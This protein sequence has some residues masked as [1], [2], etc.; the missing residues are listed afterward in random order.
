MCS[1]LPLRSGN[2]Q[3]S[4]GGKWQGEVRVQ[5]VRAV[6]EGKKGSQKAVRTKNVQ[7]GDATR[8]QKQRRGHRATLTGV[9]KSSAYLGAR[10]G[11]RP[12]MP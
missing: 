12:R 10:A 1:P 11:F 8:S 5:P 3:L 2:S 6:P 9:G 7:V 4:V